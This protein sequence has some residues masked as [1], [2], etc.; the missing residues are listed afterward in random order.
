MSSLYES[1]FY[2][3]AQQQTELLREEE[4]IRKLAEYHR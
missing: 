1:D 2:A 4:F 3:W